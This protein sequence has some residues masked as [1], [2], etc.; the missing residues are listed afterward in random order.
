MIALLGDLPR[1]PFMEG[2]FSASARQH[3]SASTCT[4][5]LQCSRSCIPKCCSSCCL[6][7]IG[8]VWHQTGERLYTIFSKVNK[9]GQE[10]REFASFLGTLLC[11]E[12]GIMHINMVTR[13]V[14]GVAS[15]HFTHGAKCQ[16]GMCLVVQPYC[17]GSLSSVLL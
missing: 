3:F 13:A 12:P 16:R 10:E 9:A 7:G 15:T 14:R 11:Y 1:V 4:Q 6:T 8:T 5:G 2:K 17:I